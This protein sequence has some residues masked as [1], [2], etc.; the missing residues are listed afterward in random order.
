MI[1]TFIVKSYTSYMSEAGAV[2]RCGSVWLV[3]L[4]TAVD[5]LAS[6]SGSKCWFIIM[7]IIMKDESK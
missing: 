3:V 1:C 5:L 7:L 2:G 6:S 4:D